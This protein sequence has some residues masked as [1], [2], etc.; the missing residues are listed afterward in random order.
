MAMV[1]RLIR[2]ARWSSSTSTR[3]GCHSCRH[4]GTDHPRHRPRSRRGALWPG[5]PC[6]CPR[7]CPAT[8]PDPPTTTSS[9]RSPLD[10]ICRNL[11]E[12]LNLVHDLARRGI[13]VRSW[14]IRCRST[15]SGRGTVTP[16]GHAKP[17]C[18]ILTQGN[19]MVSW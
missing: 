5:Q 10:R 13:G 2:S 15:G 17:S 1:S 3:F 16:T 6:T 14:P 7:R 19:G 18:F 8:R 4:A 12:V 9:T 11:R